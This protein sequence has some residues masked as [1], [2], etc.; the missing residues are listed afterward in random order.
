[1]NFTDSCSAMFGFGFGAGSANDEEDAECLEKENTFETPPW[2]RKRKLSPE[3]SSTA[4]EASDGILLDV[5]ADLQPAPDG[6][7][8]R[9][10]KTIR[11]IDNNV[12]RIS[13]S[14]LY[15]EDN[16]SLCI[17]LQPPA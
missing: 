5:D 11:Y 8:S 6:K 16:D 1:M 2:L 7:H 9:V 15:D 12:I 4:A 10:I 13:Q 3:K 14:Q 17:L